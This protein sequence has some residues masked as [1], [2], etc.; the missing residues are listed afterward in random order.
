M[1]KPHTQIPNGTRWIMSRAALSPHRGPQAYEVTRD[2]AEPFTITLDKRQ[3]QVVDTLRK[4]PLRCASPVRLSDVVHIVKRDHKLQIETEF[5]T[6]L[7][8]PDPAT[9][10]VYVLTDKLRPVSGM[11][12]QS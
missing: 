3:R 12:V 1:A 2:G 11:E 6:E 7:D 8:T 5:F 9:F 4:S 10:G